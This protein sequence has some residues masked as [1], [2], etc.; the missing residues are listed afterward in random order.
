VFGTGLSGIEANDLQASNGNLPNAAIG[1]VDQEMAAGRPLI[2]IT[3]DD[4]HRGSFGACSSLSL[5]DPSTDE[6]LESL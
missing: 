4:L 6:H 5:G 1:G 2:H 3:G